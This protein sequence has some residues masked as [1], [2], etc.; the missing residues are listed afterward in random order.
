VGSL[1]RRIY[2]RNFLIS[3]EWNIMRFLL[4]FGLFFLVP[5]CTTPL[6]PPDYST[7]KHTLL[8]F[9]EAFKRDEVAREYE[10]LSQAFKKK[11][12]SLGLS[13]YHEFRRKLADEYPLA[14][15]LFSL[16]DIEDNIGSPQITGDTADVDL[17][18]GGNTITVTLLRETIYH[19]EFD[20]GP[21]AGGLSPP[22]QTLIQE[23]EGW[24]GIMLDM[25]QKTK[26]RLMKLRKI[27]VEKRWKFLD[28]SLL[29][30]KMMDST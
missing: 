23:G 8:S 30:E 25:T 7:P 29:D 20:E 5:A 3:K 24:F 13:G 22:L 9:H 4:I 16:N 26:R 11:H 21:A 18:F 27:L 17:V 19:L 14:F 6:P 10:C 2:F 28:F 1:T 15:L 12:G